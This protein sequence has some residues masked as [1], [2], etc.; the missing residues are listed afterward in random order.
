MRFRMLDL[1]TFA[2]SNVMSSTYLSC[3]LSTLLNSLPLYS[4]VT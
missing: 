3:F 2:L 1:K 4:P